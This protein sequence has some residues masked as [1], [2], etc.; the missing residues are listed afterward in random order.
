MKNTNKTRLVL[1][2]RSKWFEMEKSGEKTEDYRE[3][4]LFWIKRLV[5]LAECVNKFSSYDI[6]WLIKELTNPFSNLARFRQFLE[7]ELTKG[8]PRKDDQS[9]RM[10][11]D[12]PLIEIGLGKGEWGAEKGKLYFKIRWDNI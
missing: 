11:F 8:Y 12:N 6:P 2:V 1:P 7:V 4:N 3:I 5:I 9:R 10:V